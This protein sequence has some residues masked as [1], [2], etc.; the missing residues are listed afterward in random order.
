M[1]LQKLYWNRRVVYAGLLLFGSI[2]MIDAFPTY[3]LLH[4]HL[5]EKIDP[6][7]DVTGLWQGSWDLFAPDPDHVNV[8]VGANLHW[9]D[10]SVTTW[11]QPNWHEMS[12]WEKMTQCRRMSFFDELWRSHNNAAWDSFCRYLATEE[13]GDRF[14]ELNKIV[15]F[16]ERDVISMPIDEWRPAYSAPQYDIH[17]KLLTW[18]ADD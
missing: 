7:I 9:K 11:Y 1:R 6:A 16:Q 13:Y 5:K 3:T 2:A 15:L 8:R 4:R 10:G 14:S 18:F 17:S 12:P